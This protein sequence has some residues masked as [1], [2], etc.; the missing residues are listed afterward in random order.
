MLKRF[1]AR[2]LIIT[3]IYSCFFQGIV[4]A[5]TLVDESSY[6]RHILSKPDEPVVDEPTPSKPQP[7]FEDAHISSFT[8]LYSEVNQR[9]ELQLALGN[10]SF[11]SPRIFTIPTPDNP[12]D[13]FAYG[14]VTVNAQSAS[15]RFQGLRV[16]IN[17]AGVMMVEGYQAKH[18]PIFL[19]SNRPIILSNIEASA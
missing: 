5:A 19:A 6:H 16:S 11:K 14:G 12:E 10:G 13:S 8:H 15:F 1:V 2:L 7:S 4:H 17:R 9:G 18:K 3:Q